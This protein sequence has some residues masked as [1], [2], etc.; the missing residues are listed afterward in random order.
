MHFHIYIKNKISSYQDKTS[1][2][3]IKLEKQSIKSLLITI[4]FSVSAANANDIP[5]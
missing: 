1:K 2:R 3:E 4:S 5:Q